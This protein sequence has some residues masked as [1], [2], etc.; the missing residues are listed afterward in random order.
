M[1]KVGIELGIAP[2]LPACCSQMCQRSR[3]EGIRP[4][5]PAGG[6]AE[7][8]AGDRR[9]VRDHARELLRRAGV[10]W[11]RAGCLRGHGQL[12][13]RLTH[14]GLAVSHVVSCSALG[15]HALGTAHVMVPQTWQSTGPRGRADV[16]LFLFAHHGPRVQPGSQPLCHP[17]LQGTL[18]CHL[19]SVE[20]RRG[21]GE[22][23]G[24]DAGTN[25]ATR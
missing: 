21:L 8:K 12:P 1:G 18:A 19:L 22:A 4:P 14:H 9:Q 17:P 11:G 15:W 25:L 24:L 6:K 23:A 3:S 2:V 16:G 13:E 5:T 20:V 7:A 10:G